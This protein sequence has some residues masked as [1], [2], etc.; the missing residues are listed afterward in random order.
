MALVPQLPGTG[1]SQRAPPQLV[2]SRTGLPRPH[3]LCE[4]K[5]PVLRSNGL[6]RIEERQ[7]RLGIKTQCRLG[8]HANLLSSSYYKGVQRACPPHRHTSPHLTPPQLQESS[9]RPSP[10]PAVLSHS[11][12]SLEFF[13]CLDAFSLLSSEEHT[14]TAQLV[15]LSG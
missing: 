10:Q 11:R 1:S 2:P 6:A 9:P 5:R 8:K 14:L 3:F 4:A 15:W 12:P 13:L 7:A